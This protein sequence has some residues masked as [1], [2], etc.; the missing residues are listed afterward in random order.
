VG[1][2]DEES[3]TGIRIV[4]RDFFR[5]MSVTELTSDD[6][7]REGEDGA[8]GIGGCG[9]GSAAGEVVDDSPRPGGSARS[10]DSNGGSPFVVVALAG[11]PVTVTSGTAARA[12]TLMPKEAGSKSTAW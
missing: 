5:D 2:V 1:E 11:E 9:I 8:V 7:T 3:G 12:G 6:V 4:G 10:G